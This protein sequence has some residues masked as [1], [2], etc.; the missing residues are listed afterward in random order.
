V[1]DW[2]LHRHN[3]NDVSDLNDLYDD[4]V[5]FDCG[6]YRICWDFWYKV[7]LEWEDLYGRGVTSAFLYLVSLSHHTFQRKLLLGW[8]LWSQHNTNQSSFC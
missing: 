8:P 3:F 7:C 5:D 1:L 6:T 4:L 2:E